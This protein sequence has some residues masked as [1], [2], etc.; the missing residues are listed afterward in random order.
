MTRWSIALLLGLVTGAPSSAC[1]QWYASFDFGAPFR[2]DKSEQVFQRNQVVDGG[3][4]RVGTSTLLDADDLDQ[5]L[6]AAGRI[7]VGNRSGIYGVEGSYLNTG[8]W[9]ESA[10]VFDATGMASPFTASGAVVNPAVDNNVS[11]VVDYTTQMESAELH[12]T[13]RVYS[14]PNGDASLF[15]GARYLGIDET[16]SYAADQDLIAPATNSIAIDV[17]SRMIGPQLGTLIE[18]PLD[19]GTVNYTFKFALARN[20]ADKST[21][22]NGT[23]GNGAGDGVALIGELDVN[24]SFAIT[25][26]LFLRLG[27]QLLAITH[28]ALATDNFGTNLAV[29]GSGTANVQMDRGLIY[30]GPYFGLLFVH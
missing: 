30:H 12:F 17:N 11:V 14:G 21:W 1:A 26:N 15:Y 19:F 5:D 18:S 3:I 10:S 6:L 16:L 29:L 13:H 22:Y 8:E 2:F 25:R 23:A 28:T 7:T 9:E 27:Y 20:E 4:T 24:G